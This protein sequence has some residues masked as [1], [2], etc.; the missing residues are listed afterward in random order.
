VVV[1]GA[2]GF[3]GRAVVSRL[4]SGFA[5]V[6]L[7][8][9]ELTTSYR[10]QAHLQWRACDLFSQLQLER[11]LAGARFAV[12]L[13]HGQLP[14]AALV[15]GNAQDRELILAANFARCARRAG[16][17]QIVRVGEVTRASDTA[18]VS[19]AAEL[20]ETFLA[21]GIPVTT[22]RV[23]VVLGQGG[24]AERLLEVLRQRPD[25]PLP[26]WA[27]TVCAPI[28]VD[29]LALKLS[30]CVG[31]QHAYGQTAEV[32]GREGVSL[33][34]CLGAH[35]AGAVLPEQ[36]L[37]RWERRL[38]L[39]AKLPESRVRTVVEGWRQP[40]KLPS[41]ELEESLARLEEGSA[42][43]RPSLD[44]AP[45]AAVPRGEHPPDVRSIQ[46]LVLPR[47]WNARDVALEYA[48]WLPTF[49]KPW[50]STS[51]TPEGRLSVVFLGVR[52]SLLELTLAS[53]R[54]SPD[55]QLFYI[56]GGGLARTATRGKPRLEFRE[57]LNGT[58]VL[59]AIHDFV[60]RLPWL[61]YRTTQA[62]FHLWVMRGFGKHLACLQAKAQPP[63][64]LPASIR[65][66]KTQL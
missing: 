28:H 6:G 37:T 38:A 30:H 17:E 55:R 62:V 35:R 58:V 24:V 54:S 64:R 42:S 39:E 12:Y 34:Q 50:V 15:Q 4:V 9:R 52:R 13:V 60:P 51:T 47:G 22:L 31:L 45:L 2:A 16:I 56:T 7:T 49:L 14:S 46:R 26:R 66:E 57:A 44:S 61:F 33:K 10:P 63:V 11:A 8:Q 32:T 25:A 20:D 18:R 29:D 19:D 48:R 23:S 21:E 41:S 27:G 43:A 59:A 1:A 3:V 53:D 65:T 5:V 40:A 36:E